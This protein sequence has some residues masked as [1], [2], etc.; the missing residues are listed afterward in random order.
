[1]VGIGCAYSL[2]VV[3]LVGSVEIDEVYLTVE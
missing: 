2:A 3:D 1:M